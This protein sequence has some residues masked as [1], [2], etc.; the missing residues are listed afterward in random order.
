MRNSEDYISSRSE[1]GDKKNIAKKQYVMFVKSKSTQR[2]Y[3]DYQLHL[4]L[5]SKIQE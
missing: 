3:Q 5:S 2:V 1:F 4:L